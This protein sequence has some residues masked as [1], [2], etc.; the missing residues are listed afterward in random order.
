MQKCAG[1]PQESESSI[2]RTIIEPSVGDVLQLVFAEADNVS[3]AITASD[4]YRSRSAADRCM[5]GH[6]WER[7]GTLGQGC[8]LLGWF[9]AAHSRQQHI[10]YRYYI[11][12]RGEPSRRA[13]PGEWSERTVRNFEFQAPYLH[14]ANHLTHH[15]IKLRLRLA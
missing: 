2:S 13:V 6:G 3:D 15:P 4:R 9:A 8:W 1:K 11:I 10:S 7:L 14:A 12:S 5:F